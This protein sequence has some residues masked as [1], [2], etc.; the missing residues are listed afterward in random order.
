MPASQVGHIGVDVLN[1]TSSRYI[2]D[3]ATYS[4]VDIVDFAPRAVSGTPAWSNLGLY[5]DVAQEKFNHGFGHW[6]FDEPASFAFNTGGIDTRWGHIQQYS[7]AK[8]FFF[9]DR[10][11]NMAAGEDGEDGSC[12][13]PSHDYNSSPFGAIEHKDDWMI[14]YSRP[15]NVSFEHEGLIIYDTNGDYYAPYGQVWVTAMEFPAGSV[16]PGNEMLLTNGKYFYAGRINDRALIGWIGT[17]QTNGNP[18]TGQVVVKDLN[19]TQAS[20]TAPFSTTNLWAIGGGETGYAFHLDSA[21]PGATAGYILASSDTNSVTCNTVGE[22]ANFTA[23]DTILLLCPTGITANPPNNIGSMEIFGGFMWGAE[24]GTNILHYWSELDGTD[25][26]GGGTT[27]TSWVEAGPSGGNI[28]GLQAFN[29]QLWIFRTDGAWVLGEDHV[30]YHTLDFE[31]LDHSF[32]FRTSTVHEG[33]MYFAV[34]DRLYKYKSGL[35]DVT[36]PAPWGNIGG[37]NYVQ[38]SNFLGMWSRGKFLYLAAE[39]EEDI[40]TYLWDGTAK[41]GTTHIIDRNE[42]YGDMEDGTVYRGIWLLCYDG[43]GWHILYKMP[44]RAIK[45]APKQSYE[46]I[47][48]NVWVHNK[49]NHIFISQGMYGRNDGTDPSYTLQ[50]VHAAGVPAT[51]FA[52]TDDYFGDAGGAT[53]IIALGSD[54][55]PAKDWYGHYFFH[56]WTV[57]GTIMPYMEDHYSWWFSSFY[58]FGMARIPKS[59]RSVT[60]VGEWP[61]EDG[62]RPANFETRTY[63][64]SRKG[65]K[66]EDTWSRLGPNNLSQNVVVHEIQFPAGYESERV[67]IALYMWSHPSAFANNMTNVVRVIILKAMM[68]PNVL[69][70][71]STDIIVA[72]DLSD[73]RRKMLGLTADEIRTRLKEARASVSP[74]TFTDIHGASTSAYLASLRFILVEYEDERG[75]RGRIEEVARCTFVNV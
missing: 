31:D 10:Y 44:A 67:Q 54:D 33:F 74:I 58:D 24:I 11:G 46:I 41:A 38:F 45:N 47:R 53:T 69:Y 70:G 61:T 64:W 23:G 12:F 16:Q 60:L 39:T 73:H 75:D 5:L 7:R 57:D 22:A 3:P 13:Y 6:T 51:P 52:W 28:V 35:Q 27:D 32:N 14:T 72:D 26:E 15:F 43:V 66:E 9:S 20:P 59:W 19:D 71:I 55:F 62:T 1:G 21:N 48:S 17:V 36:P 63:V 18:A 2:I 40:K 29:N 25:F 4:E 68:R 30:A 37:Q 34:R 8:M 42:L 50:R 49:A 56:G 65:D